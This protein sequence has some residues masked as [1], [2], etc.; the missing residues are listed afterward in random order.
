MMNTLATVLGGVLLFFG[1]WV[2]VGNVVGMISAWR[3]GTNF[4]IA[5]FF[6]GL[7]AS[8]GVVLLFGTEYAW[9]AG[10]CVLI[11][12]GGLY[13]VGSQLLYALRVRK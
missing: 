2:V 6:G 13:L 1:A 5:P 10:V 3:R 4:S 7:M 8:T 9:L 12:P 11:D